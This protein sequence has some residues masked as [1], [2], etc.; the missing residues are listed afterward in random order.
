MLLNAGADI[1][2]RQLDGI[3][4]L[5]HFVENVHR[6]GMMNEHHDEWLLGEKAIRAQLQLLSYL[7][8]EGADIHSRDSMNRSLLHFAAESSRHCDN[9]DKEKCTVLLNAMKHLIDLG[10][11]IGTRDAKGHTALGILKEFRH[12]RAARRLL[13]HIVTRRFQPHSVA[14]K[15]CSK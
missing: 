8:V 13:R 2:A 12:F 5:M 7:I 6:T 11:D 3:T 9:A 4:P 10:I 1:N 14:R 15:R